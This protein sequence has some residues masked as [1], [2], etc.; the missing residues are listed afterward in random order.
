M[1]TGNPGTDDWYYRKQGG[2]RYFEFGPFTWEKLFILFK[3]GGL[4]KDTWK[5]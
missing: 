2:D 1:G 3:Q 4:P 5:Y